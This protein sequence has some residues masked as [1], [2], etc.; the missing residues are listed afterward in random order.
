L[1]AGRCAYGRARGA[2]ADFGEVLRSVNLLIF[3]DHEDFS[4]LCSSKSFVIMKIPL[5]CSH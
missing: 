5:L 3:H 2:G 4:T 1:S